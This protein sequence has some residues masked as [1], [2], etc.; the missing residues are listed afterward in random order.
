MPFSYRRLLHKLANNGLCSQLLNWMTDFL[1]GRSQTVILEGHSSSSSEVL[2][3]VP[4]RTELAPLLFTCYVNDIPSTVK[5]KIRLY[6]DDISL[7]RTIHTDEDRLALQED[8]NAL[9][10][11]SDL[12]LMS[13]NPSKCVHLKISN[14]HHLLATKYYINQQQID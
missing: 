9:I 14:K 5:S 13:F 8:L 10:E 6:A 1:I 3:G 2:P 12:W 7:Y 11:W 4:Q